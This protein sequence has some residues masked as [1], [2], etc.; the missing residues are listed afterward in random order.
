VC[1]LHVSSSVFQV[2]NVDVLFISGE[3]HVMGGYTQT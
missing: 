2:D 1:I 3:D